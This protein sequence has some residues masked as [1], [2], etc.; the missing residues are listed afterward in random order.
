[1]RV[2]LC[3]LRFCRHLQDSPSSI[4]ASRSMYYYYYFKW[5]LESSK[6]VPNPS[7]NVCLEILDPHSVDQIDPHELTLDQN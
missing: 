5:K 4:N 7:N 1:M 6:Q 3:I 2:G